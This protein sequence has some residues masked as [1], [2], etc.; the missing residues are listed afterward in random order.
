MWHPLNYEFQWYVQINKISYGRGI[1][2][3]ETHKG[4][5]GFINILAL[6]VL[7]PN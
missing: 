2:V 1:G 6:V 3:S 5:V 7:T 4:A